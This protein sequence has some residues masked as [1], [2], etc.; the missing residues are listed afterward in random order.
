[1][2]GWKSTLYPKSKMLQT[3]A[4]RKTAR[5]RCQARP[6]SEREHELLRF[7][8]VFTRAAG[9]S[10]SLRWYFL[11]CLANASAFCVNRCSN[12]SRS[13]YVAGPPGGGKLGARSIAPL[14]LVDFPVG[15]VLVCLGAAMFSSSL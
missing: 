12:L 3:K 2:L 1:M 15:L 6:A 9:A 5:P 14:C 11:R 7:F 8:F 13:R 4:P 10:Q